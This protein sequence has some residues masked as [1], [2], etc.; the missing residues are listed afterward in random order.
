MNFYESWKFL[1]EHKMFNGSFN[2][3]LWIKVVLLNPDTN[4]IDDIK[5]NN[6]KIQ[7]WLEH[8]PYNDEFR[9][10]DHDYDLDCGGNTFEIK[11][12]QSH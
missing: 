7:F 1:E 10:C 6:T 9:A 2:D 3:D 4:E 5:E 8:G 12:P 11:P